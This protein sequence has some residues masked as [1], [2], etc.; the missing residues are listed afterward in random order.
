[1]TEP[2]E[3]Q[4]FV[5]LVGDHIPYHLRLD[6]APL[7]VCNRCGRKTWADE[8]VGTEDRMTQPDGSPCGGKFVKP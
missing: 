5:E 1:M 6:A 4:E 7:A 2:G 8:L 3:S